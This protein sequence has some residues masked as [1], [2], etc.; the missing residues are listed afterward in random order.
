MKFVSILSLLVLSAIG[1]A[2]SRRRRRRR[3]ADGE[4]GGKCANYEEEGKADI[5]CAEG[6]VCC[7]E[8]PVG[9]H[10]GVCRKE[11]EEGINEIEFKQAQDQQQQ[12]QQAGQRRRYRR[13]Y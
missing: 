6:L 8:G 12:E 13:R 11:C 10:E 9:D 4:D 5:E 3:R 2:E 7:D 1:L